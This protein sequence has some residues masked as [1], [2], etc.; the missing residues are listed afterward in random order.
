MKV[1]L[2]TSLK[3]RA[4]KILAEINSHKQPILITEHGRASAYLVDVQSFDDIRERIIILEGIARGE[5]ALRLGQVISHQQA[6][7]KFKKWFN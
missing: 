1:E 6:K 7:K 4:T 5:K 2:V 3:R